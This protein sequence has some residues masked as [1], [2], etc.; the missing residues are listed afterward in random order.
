VAE[1]QL[2][3]SDVIVKGSKLYGIQ[4]TYNGVTMASKLCEI[5]AQSTVLFE[6]LL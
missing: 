5:P 6:D 2:V 4:V 1:L 3:R